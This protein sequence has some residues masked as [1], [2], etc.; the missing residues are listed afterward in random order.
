MDHFPWGI[1]CFDVQHSDDTE[2]IIGAIALN[3]TPLKFFIMYFK[4]VK[5]NPHEDFIKGKKVWKKMNWWNSF[6]KDLWNVKSPRPLGKMTFIWPSLW[7]LLMVRKS[8]EVGCWLFRFWSK[9]KQVLDFIRHE[10]VQNLPRKLP[11]TIITYRNCAPSILFQIQNLCYSNSSESK[12]LWF[13]QFYLRPCK[14]I[15]TGENTWTF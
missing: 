1:I 8:S 10:R 4:P 9:L 3:L 13:A 12:N 2:R 5:I 14:F 11:Q 15:A 7:F 6:S